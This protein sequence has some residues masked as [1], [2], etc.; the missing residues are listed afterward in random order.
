MLT[1][2]T[3]NPCARL[4]TPTKSSFLSKKL[5]VQLDESV[6]YRTNRYFTRRVYKRK[7]YGTMKDNIW[8][9]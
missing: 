4:M 3:Q 5:P 1:R 2:L 9:K 7:I 8:S 6:A